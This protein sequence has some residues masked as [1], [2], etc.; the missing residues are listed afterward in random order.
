M[1]KDKKYLSYLNAEDFSDLKNHTH[2]INSIKASILLIISLIS[3]TG[4][5]LTVFESFVKKLSV[6]RH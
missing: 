6:V 3:E 2:Y 4:G 5:V 1:E